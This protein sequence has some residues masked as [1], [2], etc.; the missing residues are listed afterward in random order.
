MTVLDAARVTGDA[1]QVAGGGRAGA[2]HRGG[3]LLSQRGGEEAR[4]IP[5][6]TN[7]PSS[8]FSVIAAELDEVVIGFRSRPLAAGPYTF[9][10]ID[11]LTQKLREGCRTVNVHA[12]GATGVN[13]DG[14]QENFVLD[15]ATAENGAGVAG[16][17]ARLGRP[18]PVRCP[19]GRQPLSPRAV[20]RDRHDAP[21]RVLAAL[22]GA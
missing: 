1:R 10:W 3:D 11:A 5:R 19:A 18:R 6:L 2:G 22:P 9:L 20:R 7:L 14:R 16:V 17:L 4:G 12:P 15:V 21:R 13:A 8:R